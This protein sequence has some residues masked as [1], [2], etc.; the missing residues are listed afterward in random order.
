MHSNT[1]AKVTYF[2]A[3]F[4]TLR[5]NEYQ[6]KEYAQSLISYT[7]AN[8]YFRRVI[9]KAAIKLSSFFVIIISYVSG[10]TTYFVK[11]N[12]SLQRYLHI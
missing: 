9:I 6:N 4:E 3:F 8:L 7:S 2:S 11:N 12:T 10:K 5:N 1:A